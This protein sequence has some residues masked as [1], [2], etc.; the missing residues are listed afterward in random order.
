VSYDE[1]DYL[2][3]GL[4]GVSENVLENLASSTC[5]AWEGR[6]W[7]LHASR[8]A[9]RDPGGSYRISGRYNRGRD[10]FDE[11]DVFPALYLTTAPE[12]AMDEKQR[13]LTSGNLP[14]MKNQVLS[15]FRVRLRAVYD[16][17]NPEEVGIDGQVLFKDHDHALSQSL[18]AKL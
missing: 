10:F 8:Y 17:S 9:P 6:A 18:S 5:G 16:L 12:V 13:H 7:R 3:P 1:R 4:E 14:Q 2:S 11:G 15:E